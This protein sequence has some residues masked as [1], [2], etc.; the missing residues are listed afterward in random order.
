[1][2][3]RTVKTTL[4]LQ[5][6]GYIQGME[7]AAGATRMLGSEAERLAQKRQ[8]FEVLGRTLLAVGIAA[9]VGVGMAVAKFAEFDQAMS[10]VNAVTQESVEG[11]NALRDAALEAGGA[12]VFTATEAAHAQEELAKAGLSTAHILAGALSGSLA[13]AAAGQVEV[14]RSAEIMGITL[15]QFNLDG[16]QAARVADVL[17]A[18]A[19]KAVGGVEELAQGLKFV[20]PLAAAMGISLED[21]TATLALFADQ[22]ILG[23][24]AGT[25]LRGMLASLQNPSAQAK[26]KLDDL[27]ISLYDANG[28]FVGL[29]PV[30]EQ[31]NSR[32]GNVDDQTRDTA[33][34]LIFTNAQ[35]TTAQALVGEAGAK[36]GEYR[37]AV[38]DAGIAQRI[39]AERMDNLTGDVEKLGGAF[40]TA[41]IKSGSGANDTLRALVQGVT[42]LVD[43]VGDLPEPVLG[44]GLAIGTIAAVMALSGGAALLAV[45]KIAAFKAALVNTAIGAKGASLA[46]GGVG[47]ALGI[48]TVL[49]TSFISMQAEAAAAASEFRDSLNSTTGAVTAYSRELIAK[50]LIESDA[51]KG[52]ERLGVSQDEL[53]DA[54]MNG[55]DA[56]ERIK[57]LSTD[58][59]YGSLG[60]QSGGLTGEIEHLR[61]SVVEGTKDFH[62][63]KAATADNT[64]TIDQ[65]SG[66]VTAAT[67]D[68]QALKAEIEGFGSAQL[69]VNS[70]TR[71]FEASI[72]DATASV[73]EHGKTLDEGTEAGRANS[74]ALDSIAESAIALA[75]AQ[76]ETAD[77]QRK[78]TEAI[79]EGRKAY[80]AAAIAAGKTREEAEALADGLNLIPSSV[81]IVVDRSGIDLANAALTTMIQRLKLVGASATYVGVYAE[82]EGFAGGG[83]TGDGN[84][85]DIAG[86]VHKEE[87]VST[88]TTVAD[89]SNR[90]ALQYM[91]EGGS[92][93]A[94]QPMSLSG[95]QSAPPI[96]G[97]AVYNI[98]VPVTV[99]AG[100][101]TDRASLGR[102]LESVVKESLRNGDISEH[103]NSR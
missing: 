57:K 67:V 60:F 12:T 62:D 69:D 75:S 35:L 102:E 30:V 98:N 46:I 7:K 2:T 18:G 71:S 95:Y 33:L 83:Y 73:R 29:G 66:K 72:D 37:A 41:L 48:A 96:G 90:A 92:M 4:I 11:Q 99:S 22:G 25:S 91:H 86:A 32:L 16:S 23:E 93:A 74:A 81:A 56:L 55:G 17:A 20:G 65:F 19:N 6:T 54:V 38:E 77:G 80:I 101:V 3:D 40:D 94:W 58:D 13:L 44:A 79:E 97:G 47:L 42:F 68:L 88:A 64:A 5:A 103:W 26:A 36:W 84:P 51:I 24:Q 63:L 89:P 70:A 87:W 78:A 100:L 28:A 52:Y 49:I 1:M 9:A 31:L 85:R 8:S 53:T 50:K 59:F 39:A 43:M 82:I 34:G 45:P 76:V 27:N 21:T 61:D 15:K 10:Q 14:A